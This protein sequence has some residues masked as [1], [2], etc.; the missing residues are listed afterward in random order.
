M[1]AKTESN[2]EDLTVGNIDMGTTGTDNLTVSTG[3]EE[4]GAIHEAGPLN[5]E[6]DIE[7]TVSTVTDNDITPSVSPQQTTGEPTDDTLTET[8]EDS[9]DEDNDATDTGRLSYLEMYQRLSPFK[10]PTDEELERERRKARRDKTFAAIGDGIA[11]LSNLFFTTRGA[12][13]AYNGGHSLSGKT[14]ERWDKLIKEREANQ[15]EYMRGYLEAMRMDEAANK[16]DRNWR[17]SLEREARSDTWT[18]YKE[19]QQKAKDQLEI[20]KKEKELEYLSG[21]ISYQQLLNDIKEAEKEYI[22]TYGQKMPTTP[23]PSGSGGGGC[24][25]GG[26]TQTWTIVNDT[27]KETKTIH[28]K[29]EAHARNQVPDGWSLAGGV[30]VTTTE[31]ENGPFG[32]T[33]KTTTQYVTGGTNNKGKEKKKTGIEKWQ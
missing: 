14:R 28:A 17:H 22:D 4:T 1:A 19:E 32:G 11:A 21:K 27:T 29:S 24:G 33:S 13:N 18:E 23:K 30:R 31:T 8:I 9:D 25:G 16:D 20:K 12:P 15:R 2:T 10:P 6:T 3:G 5:T 7:H 26:G